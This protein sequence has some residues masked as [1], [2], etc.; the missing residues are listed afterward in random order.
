MNTLNQYELLVGWPKKENV[1]IYSHKIH[2]VHDWW[3]K[4]EQPSI[5]FLITHIPPIH[6]KFAKSISNSQS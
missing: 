5:F 3:L 1:N 4:L 2:R 6:S